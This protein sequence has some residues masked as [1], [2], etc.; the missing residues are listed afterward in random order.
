LVMQAYQKIANSR[1]LAFAD[2]ATYTKEQIERVFG[3]EMALEIVQENAK[4]AAAGICG[5][6]VQ[7][8]FAQIVEQLQKLPNVEALKK[9]YADAQIK[10]S[11]TDIGVSD[12]KKEALLMHAPM[13]RNRL[14]LLRLFS[15]GVIR[16]S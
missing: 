12:E 5:E 13:V 14:T 4:D 15:G 7:A 3:K 6:T 9:M 2:Y 10:A 1:S 8:C 16:L 11:L